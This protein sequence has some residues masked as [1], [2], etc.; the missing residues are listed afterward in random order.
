MA[1]PK[2]KYG[3]KDIARECGISPA[4]V[5]RVFHQHPNVKDSIREKVFLAAERNNYR[6][7]DKSVRKVI[8][9]ILPDLSR[10]P[11]GIYHNALIPPL[12]EKI[13][14]H[15]YRALLVPQDDLELMRRYFIFGVIAIAF[16]DEIV[17]DWENN[18]SIPLV[19]ISSP[20]K[21]L[22]N[23]YSVNSDEEH[24]MYLAVNHLVKNGHSK[25][26]LIIDGTLEL[27]ITKRKRYAGFIKALEKM[28]CMADGD[29]IQM[30]PDENWTLALGRML[31]NGATAVICSGESSGFKVDYIM[32]LFAKKI[33]EEISIITFENKIISQYC[34]PPHTTISQDF[35]KLAAEAVALVD[36]AMKDPSHAKDV[37]VD[38]TLIER[39]SVKKLVESK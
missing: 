13:H 25:I 6:P 29:L 11:F 22:E 2:V 1:R 31:R 32:N 21:R 8:G 34:N 24:G 38:Y 30:V 23:A 39:E 12:I 9:I 15:G 27:N 18:F 16:C 36:L 5:S 20:G 37:L 35:D 14:Q 17:R 26:G 28:G 10:H 33:P 4:T 3:I 19:V 7:E